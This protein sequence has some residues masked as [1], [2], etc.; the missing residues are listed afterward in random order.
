MFMMTN[1]PIAKART[2]LWLGKAKATPGVAKTDRRRIHAK[3]G[4]TEEDSWLSPSPTLAQGGAQTDGV[5]LVPKSS[6]RPPS[7]PSTSSAQACCTSGTTTKSASRCSTGPPLQQSPLQKPPHN[8]R[9]R[10][11]PCLKKGKVKKCDYLFWIL[12]IQNLPEL[13]QERILWG[14]LGALF[15]GTLNGS[16]GPL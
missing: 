10:D 7:C 12:K 11:Q 8:L 1:W 3:S 13:I 4:I 6:T 2:I 15:M 5:Q 14:M 9:C 16:F